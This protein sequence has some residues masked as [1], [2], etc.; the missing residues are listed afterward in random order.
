M[1]PGQRC[2][3]HRGHGDAG[4]P[5]SHSPLAM[6]ID[7]GTS[8]WPFCPYVEPGELGPLDQLIE[9]LERYFLVNDYRFVRAAVETYVA[10][11]VSQYR[12]GLAFIAEHGRHSFDREQAR[13][14]IEAGDDCAPAR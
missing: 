9:D 14:A 11:R 3:A 12:Q 7:Y 10:A 13:R 5:H 6:R 8:E 4:V 2:T 1:K